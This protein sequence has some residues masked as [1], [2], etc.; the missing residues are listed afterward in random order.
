VEK[1]N[2]SDHYSSHLYV[3]CFRRTYAHYL[4]SGNNA[5]LMQIEKAA[6]WLMHRVEANRQRVPANH[7]VNPQTGIPDS[8]L[9]ELLKHAAI[10]G[11]YIMA[12]YDGDAAAWERAA[13]LISSRV[14][15]YLRRHSVTSLG[16]EIQAEDII[17]SCSEATWHW[18]EKY[19][20]DCKL[21]AWLSQCIAHRV[22]EICF[23]A[24]H[25]RSTRSV[26]IED[27]IKGDESLTIGDMLPDQ[28][29]QAQF[30]EAEIVMALEMALA[31]L[32]VRQQASILGAIKGETAQTIAARIGCN[33]NAVYKLQERARKSL[34][35]M[36]ELAH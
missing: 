1:R 29:A 34:R 30:S 4:R 8:Y 7:P 19:T 5:V 28:A 26:S 33:P 13:C 35:R 15:G 16:R 14:H 36:L 12:L 2:M 23:S 9:D 24:G 18:L 17:Q 31:R 21:E 22:H 32:P 11:P 10:E 20:Y 25:R 6:D 27:A 3:Q